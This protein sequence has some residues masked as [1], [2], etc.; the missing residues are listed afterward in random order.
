MNGT[1]QN[2]FPNPKI[3]PSTSPLMKPPTKSIGMNMNK[4][5][6]KRRLAG[7]TNEK[8]AVERVLEFFRF[9]EIVHLIFFRN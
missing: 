2:Q 4:F 9:D 5:D 1:D 8:E 6:C 7:F 3:S